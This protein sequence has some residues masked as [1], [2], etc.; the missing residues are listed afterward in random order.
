MK[1]YS[2]QFTL[3][4]DTTFGRGDGMA[5]L[6]DRE[7]AHDAQGFPYLNGRALKGLITEEC[8]ALLEV[9]AKISEAQSLILREGRDWMFGRPGSRSGSTG[10]L[11]VSHARLP[12]NLR[13]A[14]QAAKVPAADVLN[15]LTT[16]RR[17]SAINME[18][19]APE[20]H[21]LRSSRAILRETMF[22]SEISAPRDLFDAELALL[23]A[24]ILHWRR[25]GS[26]RNRGRGRVRAD[27]FD[28]E[29]KSALA[30]GLRLLEV[31]P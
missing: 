31:R 30:M 28:A 25:A 18:T 20:A 4:S 26:I 21:T 13:A 14:V 11:H 7:V 17:Q 8:E 9:I 22:V 1:T 29:G 15:S 2:L 12:A 27:L 5:G 23:A 3:K 10:A 24:S 19:G 6:I 16:I